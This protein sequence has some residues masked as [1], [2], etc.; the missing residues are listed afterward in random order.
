MTN[1]VLI[2]A[3]KAAYEAYCAA[4]APNVLPLPWDAQSDDTKAIAIAQAK[5]VLDIVKEPTPIMMERGHNASYHKLTANEAGI[6][7]DSMFDAMLKDG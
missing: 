2:R 7:W 6:L 1:P 5:A 4:V 3:A